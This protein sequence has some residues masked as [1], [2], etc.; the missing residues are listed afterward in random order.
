MKFRI[1]AEV[2]EAHPSRSLGEKVYN[3]YVSQKSMMDLAN[4][5]TNLGY[6]CKYLGGMEH[7]IKYIKIIL[8]LKILYS[9]IITMDFLLNIS[10]F[11]VLHYWN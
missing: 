5:I 4:G 2:R 1:I 8:F 7:Y 10:V 6:D 9:S 3:D 11:K